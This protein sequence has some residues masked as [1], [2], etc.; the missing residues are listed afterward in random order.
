LKKADFSGWVTKNDIRC[1]DGVT[2][3]HDAFKNNDNT[4]VPIV[5]QH[6]YSSPTNVLGHM[7]LKHADE[8][9]YGYGYFNDNEFAQDTLHLLKHGDINAMSIGARAMKT[10]SGDVVSGEIYEVSLVLKGANPGAKIEH[11]LTHSMD[12]V[13]NG[14]TTV[15]H[16]GITQ[17]LLKGV[18]VE[19]F[20]LNHAEDAQAA[21]A[22]P[23]DEKKPAQDAQPKEDG[24]KSESGDEKTIKDVL[25]TLSEEQQIAVSALIGQIL[26]DNG[27]DADDGEDENEDED[28]EDVKDTKPAKSAKNS[29]DSKDDETEEDVKQSYILEGETDLKH[30]VFESGQQQQQV[31]PNPQIVNLVQS[32]AASRANSLAGVLASA[33]VQGVDIQHGISNIDTLFP[34]PALD[35]GLQVYQLPGAELTESILAKFTKSPRSRVKRM[36]A[37]IT[38]DEARARGYITGDQKLDSMYSV[39]YRETTPGTIVHHE[40]LDRD[41]II[42]IQEGGIDIIN[43]T[44]NVMQQKLK[45]ELVRAA[46]IGDGR[47][48]LTSDNKLNR[49]KI[50]ESNIRPAISDDD[51]FTIKVTTAN[52]TSVVDDLARTFPAYQGS[53]VPTL[54]INP[55]DLAHLKTLKDQSGHYLY[56]GSFD[57]NALPTDQAI[58]AYFQCSEVVPY[59]PLPRG[60]MLVGNLADYTIGSVKG[61]E[62]TNFEDF[63]IDFNQYKY[64][65]ETRLSGAITTPKSFIAITVTSP[66]TTPDVAKLTK[67]SKDQG[68]SLKDTADYTLDTGS[69]EKQ[70]AVKKNRTDRDAKLKE[71]I[72]NGNNF[73]S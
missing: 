50:D 12:G 5:W 40:T 65:A 56:S 49:F 33:G 8:G 34:A 36:W 3:R 32:A 62:I 58:A 15:I 11:V 22:A 4:Q 7:M 29:K 48:K 1:A 69:E 59:M 44:K 53:G 52:M 31:G 68:K 17:N 14:E 10:A 25:D 61:G 71:A 38:E 54:F 27:I 51:L 45:E 66:E 9:V 55:F 24:T 35:G 21:A 37:N 39:L 30:N 2:I 67:F 70:A 72:K 19:E 63:D 20:T 18:D 26:E 6:D 42:D 41:D 73:P 13:E 47:S 57:K 16:T 23:K 43:F 60:K 46:L 28:T 64:L